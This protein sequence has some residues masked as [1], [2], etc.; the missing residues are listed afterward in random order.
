MCLAV[1]QIAFSFPSLFDNNSLKLW[2]DSI[3][4]TFRIE[5]DLSLKTMANVMKNGDIRQLVAMALQTCFSNQSLFIIEFK[6]GF[7]LFLF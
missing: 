5:K 4:C 2:I 7:F 6:K 3:Q 1:A